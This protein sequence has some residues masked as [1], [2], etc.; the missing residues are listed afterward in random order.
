MDEENETKIKH[1]KTLSIFSHFERGFKND[2]ANVAEMCTLSWNCVIK[3]G[4]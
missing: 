2:T 3:P 4:I 1:L